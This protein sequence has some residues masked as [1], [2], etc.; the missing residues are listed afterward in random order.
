MILTGHFA[1]ALEVH[2]AAVHHAE[3]PCHHGQ[4]AEHVHVVQR[5]V[6]DVDERE[7]RAA[8]VQQRRRS[9]LIDFG[10]LAKMLGRDPPRLK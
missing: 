9:R 2:I 1:Q 7:H 10:S 6:T 5:A 8:Q 4:E 3:G